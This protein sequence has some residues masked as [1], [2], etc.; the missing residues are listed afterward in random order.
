MNNY[1]FS[2]RFLFV[3]VSHICMSVIVEPY[4]PE[5]IRWFE[6]LREPIWD[7]IGDIVVDIVHVGSTSIEGM[8][9]KPVIDIDIVVASWDY[10]TEIINRLGKLGYKHQGDLGIKE[11]EAFKQTRKPVHPH[12]LYVCHRDSIAYKNHILLK[13]HLTENPEA[14]RRYEQL[15][16]SLGK[17]ASD[18]DTYCR[19]KTEIILEFLAAEGV[20]DEE[21][22]EIRS[23]NLS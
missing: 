1:E 3:A 15:K 10:F 9:A 13:K 5:W 4:N 12:N 6:E 8:S 23:E 14:F 11:R 7:M 16:I 22:E 21:L 19:Q 17:T 2:N 18:V 20:P